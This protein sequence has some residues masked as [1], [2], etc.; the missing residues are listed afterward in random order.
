MKKILIDTSFTS[1][2]DLNTG[3]QRVVRKIIENM[4]SVAKGTKYTPIQVVLQDDKIKPL[5]LDSEIEV[6]SGDILLLLDSTWHLDTWGSIRYAKSQGAMI[7]AVIYDIIPISHPQYCDAN[8]VKLF[9]EWFKISIN[10]VDGFIAISHTVQNDLQ[11]YLKESYPEK[12]KD[13]FFDH[14]LLGADFEYTEFD[15]FSKNT[16]QDLVQLYSDTQKSI[17]LIV[18]T[19]EPRKNHTY[20]LDAFDKLWNQNIDVTL[21]IVGKTGWMVDDLMARIHNHPHYNKKLFHFDNLNDEELNYCYKNSKMLL[22]PSFVEGFGLPIIESLNN[23]LPVMASDTPIHNEVGGKTIGYFD[24]NNPQDLTDKILDIEK[25]SIP[26]SLQIKKN[27]KWLNWNES[28]GILFKKVKKFDK[29]FVPNP[30]VIKAP[31]PSISKK[32][33]KDKI[34]S[35]PVLGWFMRWSYNLL[36]LNNIKHTLFLTTQ[37]TNKLIIQVHNQ[38]QQIQSQ[39]QQIQSQAQQIQSQA[40]Q[41]QSQAQQIQSQAQQ[42]ENHSH[43]FVSQTNAIQDHTKQIQTNSNQIKTNQTNINNLLTHN[44][45]H[46]ENYK[47]IQTTIQQNIHTKV[48]R[49]ISKQSQLFHQRI[50]QFIQELQDSTPAD[51]AKLTNKIQEQ[52]NAINFDDFYMNYENIFRGSR[53]LI[54]E[55]FQ[56]YFNYIPK[57]IDKSLDIGCGRAEWVE[58]QQLRGIDATGID[59][60]QSLLN[61]ASSQDVKN[62]QKIDAFEYLANCQDNSFDLVSAFHII[63]HIPHKD[64]I[65]LLQEIKRVSKPNATI[66]LE[67]PNPENLKV[68]AFTFYRDPTHLNPLPADVMKFTLEY[69]GFEDIKVN[70]LHSEPKKLTDDSLAAKEIN[71]YLYS[72]QDYLLVAKNAN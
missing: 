52:S 11:N 61:I 60:N 16:R 5:S 71:H 21:N 53:E 36:R 47:N 27:F 70:Y 34:K 42:V 9:K 41:I 38:A 48:S 67:T 55:R 32:T 13:K 25:N 50:T 62:L 17:Y 49:E 14:F 65:K 54:Q 46:H 51:N 29:K 1:T 20:L 39:A 66:L 57:I 6:S 45:Q 8:L 43:Q 12:I 18:C 59:L 7:V 3:I 69:L 4:D 31:K 23:H 72:A 58:L 19:V 26:K 68:A 30:A 64:L 15:I 22:F 37:Q 24:L 56:E 10:Y 63:E 28:T 35:L 40:Q 33:I 2:T 44:H